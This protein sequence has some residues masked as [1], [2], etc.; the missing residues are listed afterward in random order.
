[1]M[2]MMSRRVMFPK[3]LPHVRFSEP[4]PLHRGCNLSPAAVAAHTLPYNPMLVLSPKT[5]KPCAH[6]LP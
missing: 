5:L 4:A 6:T 1:M 3:R 2:M